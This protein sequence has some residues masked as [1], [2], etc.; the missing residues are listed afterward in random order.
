VTKAIYEFFLKNSM[1]QNFT[2]SDAGFFF[3]PLPIEIT[4][5]LMFFALF[6]FERFQT[7][8]KVEGYNDF[9]T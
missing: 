9:F 7:Y 8:R 3:F 5:S 6:D 2:F 1:R 4:I